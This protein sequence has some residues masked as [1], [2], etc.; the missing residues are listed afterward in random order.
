DRGASSPLTELLLERDCKMLSKMATSLL[1][2]AVAV[3]APHAALAQS[4]DVAID[5]G[6]VRGSAAEGV[7]SWKGIPFAQ[8]PVGDLRRRAPQPVEPW[9]GVREAT[10]YSH[11]CMQVPFPS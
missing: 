8:P 3:A 6:T 7:L 2:A 1:A 5:S 11:D 9:R 4:T 10:E